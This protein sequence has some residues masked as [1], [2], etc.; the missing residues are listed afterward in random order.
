MG[1]AMVYVFIIFGMLFL[2]NADKKKVSIIFFSGISFIIF[3][4]IIH[5]VFGIP[6]FLSDYQIQRFTVFLNPYNDGKNGLGAGYNIIQSIIA[7]GSGGFFGKGFMKGTQITFI[8]EHHTDFIFSVIGEEFGF[9]GVIILIIIYFIFIIKALSIAHECLDY[10]GFII[11]IGFISMFLF[12]IL[13]NIGMSIGLMPVT[14]I[15]L[16]FISL[17]GSNLW[18][19]FC[20]CGIILNISTKRPSRTLF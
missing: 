15:P 2:S 19:N 6:I 18:T 4:I 17:G 3:W 5:I 9:V 16:P 12:H 7:I 20:A 11:T 13:E 10:Y 14:G 1:T 8:P